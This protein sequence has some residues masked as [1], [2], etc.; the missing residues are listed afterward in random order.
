MVNNCIILIISFRN[1]V[2]KVGRFNADGL[3]GGSA[4]SS[5]VKYI[6]SISYVKYIH[7][8]AKGGGEGRKG[9]E[10]MEERGKE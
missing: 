2:S 10:G 7:G 9:K 4:D 6:L 5:I 8:Q 3:V 1:C